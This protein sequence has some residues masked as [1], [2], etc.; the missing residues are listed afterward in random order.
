MLD[1]IFSYGQNSGNPN[2]VCKKILFNIASNINDNAVSGYICSKNTKHKRLA[3]KRN[4][5][6][7]DCILTILI[8]KYILY[9]LE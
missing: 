3:D 9:D 6:K 7:N 2:L 4:I 5:K 8:L 1:R